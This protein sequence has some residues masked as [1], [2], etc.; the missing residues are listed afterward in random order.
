SNARHR[1]VAPRRWSGYLPVRL[2]SKQCRKL[3]VPLSVHQW[4]AR[5][6][7]S[8]QLSTNAM[9]SSLDSPVRLSKHSFEKETARIPRRAGCRGSYPLRGIQGKRS[10]EHTSELQSHLNIVCR[11]LPEKKTNKI[12]T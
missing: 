3:C 10:E 11:L 2:L 7:K 8:M 12:F 9:A 1:S 6:Y 5:G 4:P